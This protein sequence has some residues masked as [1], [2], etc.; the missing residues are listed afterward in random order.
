MLAFARASFGRVGNLTERR[1]AEGLHAVEQLDDPFHLTPPSPPRRGRSFV[2]YFIKA[3]FYL[4][5][6]PRH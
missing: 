6:R 4:Q 1:P 3:R 2:A 5:L